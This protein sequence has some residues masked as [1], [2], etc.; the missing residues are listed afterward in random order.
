MVL[1]RKTRSLEAVGP[2]GFTAADERLLIAFELA[3]VINVLA[4]IVILP[5]VVMENVVHSAERSAS[6]R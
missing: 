3:V 6:Y 4:C 1:K 2:T 5:T